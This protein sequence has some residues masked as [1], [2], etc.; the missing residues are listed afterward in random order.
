MLTDERHAAQDA[1]VAAET[2]DEI[3]TF[4]ESL[5]A[6]DERRGPPNLVALGAQP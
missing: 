1:P 4:G 3:E 2:D 6:R 5:V